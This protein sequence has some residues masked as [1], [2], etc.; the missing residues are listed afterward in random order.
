MVHPILDILKGTPNEWLGHLLLTFNAGDI[1]KFDVLSSTHFAKVDVLAK[2]TAFLRQKLCLMA[3]I[4]LVFQRADRRVPFDV[5]R[6]AIRLPADEVNP[7]TS[8][9]ITYDLFLFVSFFLWI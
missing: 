4:E 6:E 3:L 9:T 2:N 5:I 7:N 8:L 1:G